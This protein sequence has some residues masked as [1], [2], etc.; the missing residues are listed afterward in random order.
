MNNLKQIGLA[1]HNYH[2]SNNTFPM[3]SSQGPYDY[4]FDNTGFPAWDSWSAQALMLGY[5]EQGPLVQ[6]GQFQL[7]GRLDGQPSWYD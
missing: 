2:T 3:G 4:Q 1:M 5:M 6:R 7:C